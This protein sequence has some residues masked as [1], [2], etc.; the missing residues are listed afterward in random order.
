L[1]LRVSGFGIDGTTLSRRLLDQNVCATPMAGWGETH[2]ADYIRFVYANE[3]VER[4]K[5][6]GPAVRAALGA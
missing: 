2:G 1:L 4:L 3:P 5:R 6:L